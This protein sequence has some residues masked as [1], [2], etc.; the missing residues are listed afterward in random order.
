MWK[1]LV[2][3]LISVLI[4]DAFYFTITQMALVFIVNKYNNQYLKG[5]LAM[6]VGNYIR[7]DSS[8][9]ASKPHLDGCLNNCADFSWLEY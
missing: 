5:S 2:K 1:Y 3:V 6:G 8:T 7:F 4:D 9:E